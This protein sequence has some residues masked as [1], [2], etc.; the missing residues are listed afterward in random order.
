MSFLVMSMVKSWRSPSCIALVELMAF[1]ALAVDVGMLWT[2]RRQMQ[3]A[4]DA[5]AVAGAVALRDGD[6]V[7]TAAAEAATLNSFTNGQNNTTVT[8]NNPPLSGAYA[9]NSNYVEAIVYRPETT[10]FLRA[11]GYKTVNVQTRAVSGAINGPGLHVR[12]GSHQSAAIGM[13]GSM[14]IT[15]SCGVIDDSNS[16]QRAQRNR[17]RQ[18]DGN[19]DRRG[20]WLLLYRQH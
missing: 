19:F 2:E 9:G 20:G 11:L 16:Q 10:Y 17:Q 18:F 4:V 12:S 8:V 13:T 7:Q 14:E 5:A 3:T 15:L 1:L 6:N